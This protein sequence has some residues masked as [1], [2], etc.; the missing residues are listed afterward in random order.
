[1]ARDGLFFASAGKL[2][3]FRVPGR[4]LLLQGLW[5]AFLVLPRTFNPATGAYSNLYGSLLDYVVSAALVFYIVTI[6]GVFRLRWT[7]PVSA[8]PVSGLWLSDRAGALHPRGDRDPRHPGDLPR[9]VAALSVASATLWDEHREADGRAPC[10]GLLPQA[11]V[12]SHPTGDADRS[13]VEPLRQRGRSGRAGS[14]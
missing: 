10:L 2:N 4:G 5:A 11:A 7:Q 14:G 13:R 6:A 12:G 3:R 1:M 8:A 9:L